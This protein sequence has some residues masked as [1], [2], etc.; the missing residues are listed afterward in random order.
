[1]P[2]QIQRLDEN[3]GEFGWLLPAERPR[4]DRVAREV[5]ARLRALPPSPRALIHRDFHGGNMLADGDRLSLLDFED[6][7]LGEP[8]DDVA[9]NWVQLTR[10]ALRDAGAAPAIE[11]GRRAFLEGY[12]LEGTPSAACLPTFVAMH[13]FLSAHQSLRH[14]R[15][16]NRESAARTML[17][18]SEDVLAR[19]L[20]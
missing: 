10:Y 12:A 18:V 19:D 2:E 17:A 6:C 20:L 3:A 9:M 14:P 1:M 5:S 7:A 4:I 8:A 16:A 13:A 15:D 11:A